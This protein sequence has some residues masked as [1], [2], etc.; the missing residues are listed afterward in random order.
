MTRLALGALA[1]AIALAA[2]L[3]IR[4]DFWMGFLFTTLLF[5]Y[6]GMAWNVLGGYAGQF[7]FGH[8][9]FFGTGAYAATVLNLSYGLNP[10]LGLVAAAAA[11][12]LVAALIGYLSFRYGLK[13]SYFALITLAFAEVFRILANTATFTGGGVGLYIP[14]RIGPE[15]LQ[16]AAKAGFYYLVLGLNVVSLLVAFYLE[17]SRFGAW[18]KAIRE[19]EDAARAL[20]VNSFACK[21]KAIALSGAMTAVG[22]VVY[23]QHY[24]YIDPGIAYG[25][26]VSVEIL[27][28]PI[29]GGM[30]TVLGPLVGSAVLQGAGEL[31]RRLMGEAPGLSLAFYGVLLVVM[32][33]FLPDGLIG[34][35]GRARRRTDGGT[36]A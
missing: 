26:G 12:A 30:G 9:V 24:L 23:A 10:W 20:G 15:N 1:A 31:A 19:N 25:P 2:P 7:S 29:I 3:L 35:L 5:A 32:V 16:F 33:R 11:G 14:L 36:H 34:L 13:G 18:L 28:V 22:G 4:S 27:L 17:R 8:A 21:L 6:M